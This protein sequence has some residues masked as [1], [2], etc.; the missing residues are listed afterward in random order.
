MLHVRSLLTAVGVDANNEIYLVAYA[1][2]EAK[3]MASWCWFLNLLGDDLGIEVNFNYTFLS[4][5][6]KGLIQAITSVFPSAEHKYYVRHIHENM[7]SQ[8]KED[9]YK[10][11][12]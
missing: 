8:F 10:K 9:V 3:S 2:V 11:M 7:K 5:M 6:Q 4:N 1:I 12:L